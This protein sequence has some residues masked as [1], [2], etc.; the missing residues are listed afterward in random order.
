MRQCSWFFF[1]LM[2]MSFAQAK[3]PEYDRLAGFAEHQKSQKKLNRDRE[4]QELEHFEEQYRWELQRLAAVQEHKKQK[5]VE[6]P[7]EGGAEWKEDQAE[8][9][10]YEADLERARQAHVLKRDQFNRNQHPELPTE[11][12]ELDL[13]GQKRPRYDLKKRASFG[14]PSKWGA[15]GGTLSGSSRSGGGSSSGGSAFPPPPPFDD[16]SDDGFVPAPNLGENFDS[17][18]FPPPPP[19]PPFSDGGDFPDLPPPIPSDFGEGIPD[20]F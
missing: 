19:P 9:Q 17:S 3:H 16:F 14:A 8:K 5:A 12:E 11:E 7:R 2:S 1:I 18:D 20:A 10:A 4:A 13:V 6:S 15:Q